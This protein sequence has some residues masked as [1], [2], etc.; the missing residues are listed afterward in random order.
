MQRK[1]AVTNKAKATEMGGDF[2]VFYSARYN[3]HIPPNLICQP[4]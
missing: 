2:K 3:C 4:T 1:K